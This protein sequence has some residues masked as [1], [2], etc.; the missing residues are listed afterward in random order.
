MDSVLF[1]FR[2]PNYIYILILH[3][4]FCILHLLKYK[5]ILFRQPEILYCALKFLACVV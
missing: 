5:L 2:K 3:F 1:I 4:A